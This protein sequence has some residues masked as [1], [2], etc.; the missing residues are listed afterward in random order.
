MIESMFAKMSYH[1][2]EAKG[3][4]LENIA[5]VQAFDNA[6][7]DGLKPV[8]MKKRPESRLFQ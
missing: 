2:D 6:Y 1:T 8:E 5:V 3:Y 7:G 4:L